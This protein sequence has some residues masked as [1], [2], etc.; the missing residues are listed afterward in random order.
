MKGE[1]ENGSLFVTVAY[2]EVMTCMLLM[3]LEFQAT[4][5]ELSCQLLTKEVSWEIGFSGEL[6]TT[7]LQIGQAPL[8]S[9]CR[10]VSCLSPTRLNPTLHPNVTTAPSPILSGT[11]RNPFS[12][13]PSSLHPVCPMVDDCIHT[14]SSLS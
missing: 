7:W 11:R 10:Q 13:S 4:R 1:L 9:P 3:G 8:H 6:P 14:Q 12:G 2:G 5:M